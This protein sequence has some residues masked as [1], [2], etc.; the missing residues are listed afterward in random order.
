MKGLLAAFFAQVVII[1]YRSTVSGTSYTLKTPTTAPLPLPL[2][3]D[4]TAAALVYGGLAVL[5]NSLGPV[6]ALLGWGFVVANLLNL[7]LTSSKKPVT[8]APS[9]TKAAAPTK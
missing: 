2:P 1:T 9:V 4:Y 8:K 3:A 7:G 6:P 5:P